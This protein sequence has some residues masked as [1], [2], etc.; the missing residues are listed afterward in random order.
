[1]EEE[2]M[3][4]LDEM[5]LKRSKDFPTP[6]LHVQVFN[7]SIVARP[8]APL[9]GTETSSTRS[10]P[11]DAAVNANEHVTPSLQPAAAAPGRGIQQWRGQW[12]G[13]WRE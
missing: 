8:D 11:A 13:Q 4:W 12:R 5:A 6:F 1:M 7:I 3:K 9:L 10:F 2:K